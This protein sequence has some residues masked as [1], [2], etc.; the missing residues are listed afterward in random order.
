MLNNEIHMRLTIHALEWSMTT[1][2]S[3]SH[4]GART[5]QIQVPYTIIDCFMT[6]HFFA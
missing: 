6:T 3:S 4:R 5:P 2:F 1:E